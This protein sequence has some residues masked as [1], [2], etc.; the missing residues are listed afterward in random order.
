[1]K[2]PFEIIT[3]HCKANQKNTC[4]RDLAYSIYRQQFESLTRD[5]SLD[6]NAIQA[7][8]LSAG[9]LNAHVRSAEDSLRTQFDEDLKPIKAKAKRESFLFSVSAG[10]IGNLAYSLVLILVF[11]IAKDQLTSWLTGLLPPKQ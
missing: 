7:T 8:L 9:N 5:A 4:I 11:I 1:M 2:T 3:D 10:V 6:S